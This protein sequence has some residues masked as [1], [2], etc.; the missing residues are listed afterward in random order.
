MSHPDTSA[1][2]SRK[3]L[4]RPLW[5]EAGL[6]AGAA[7]WITAAVLLSWQTPWMTG[8]T[9][10]LGSWAMLRLWPSAKQGFLCGALLGVVGE[11][12]C[13]RPAVAFWVYAP[14]SCSFGLKVPFWLPLVW[15]MLMT[16]FHRIGILLAGAVVLPRPLA[17][18]VKVLAFLGQ[19]V[20]LLG[21]PVWVR[22]YPILPQ[23][24]A[25]YGILLGAM[26]WRWNEGEDLATF[27]AAGLLGAFGEY[28][29]IHQGIWHYPTPIRGMPWPLWD[30]DSPVRI[31][32]AVTLPL[33][34]GFSAVVVA[35]LGR[36][37]G[38]PGA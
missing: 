25:V 7:I 34:W 14:A 10:G 33:A 5:Q 36:W 32:V 16:L 27:Y 2:M 28:L 31:P 19:I 4:L 23:C 38:R 29:C 21:L 12:I 9:L 3:R 30:L 22:P 8:L 17:N 20:F 37:W 13:T 11:L 35:R 26:L 6:L 18:T 24:L 15:G 1:G